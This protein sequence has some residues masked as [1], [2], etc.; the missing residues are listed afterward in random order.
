MKWCVMVI[1]VGDIHYAN[2]SKKVLVDYFSRNKITYHFVEKTPNIELRNSHPSWWKLLAHKI[3]PGYD[4]IICWDLDMLPSS[5]TVKCFEEFNPNQLCLAWDL[6]AKHFPESKFIPEF[7]YNGGLIGYPSSAVPFM[8]EVFN[9]YAPGTYPSYEQYYLNQ[10][11]ARQS[12]PVYEFPGDIN[13]L[14]GAPEFETARLKHYT[15][16][17][18][19]KSKI[20]DHVV[21]YFEQLESDDTIVKKCKP[22]TMI[23]EERMKQNMKSIELIECNSIPGDIVEIGVWKG[24]SMLSMILKYQTYQKQDRTF[25]LY[26][27]FTGMTEPTA[28]DSDI[29]GTPAQHIIH[30]PGI[31]AE[32]SLDEVKSN[33]FINTSYNKIEFH[34]GDIM[35]NTFYPESIAV[36]R[37]DTDFYDSTKHELEHFYNIVSPGGVVLIDDYGHWKGCRKAVDEFLDKHPNITIVPIDYT[38]VYFVKP[39]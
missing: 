5:P 18:D 27:T 4:Y 26:D 19:A 38:G 16:R 39:Y 1:C 10:E 17:D 2:D 8:E 25:H 32:C 34:K 23:S 22:Y 37:L 20:H 15:G 24:G 12:Y 13:V 7:K 35:K 29:N 6:V 30:H 31:K 21:R 11:I 28:Y 3:L 14:Y 9:K 36:L 33:L